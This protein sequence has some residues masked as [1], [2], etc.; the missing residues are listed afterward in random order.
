MRTRFSRFL[1]EAFNPRYWNDAIKLAGRDLST[2]SAKRNF[3]R[4]QLGELA[5]K[6]RIP[7]RLIRETP[8]VDGEPIDVAVLNMLEGMSAF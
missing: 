8:C 3:I 1:D 5:D 2:Q 6:H 7:Q 4:K